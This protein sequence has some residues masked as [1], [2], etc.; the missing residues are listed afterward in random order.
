MRGYIRVSRLLNLPRHPTAEY[1]LRVDAVQAVGIPADDAIENGAAC[2]IELRQ[3]MGM[4][5]FTKETLPE[6]CE[7][8]E[9]A[10]REL[11]EMAQN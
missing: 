9:L 2:V 3:P 1:H 11:R 8:I 5:V 7:Q 4:Q 6:V 10:E